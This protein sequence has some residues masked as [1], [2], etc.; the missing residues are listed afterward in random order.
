MPIPRL[1]SKKQLQLDRWFHDTKQDPLEAS[2]ATASQSSAANQSTQCGLTADEVEK[3]AARA[4]ARRNVL[5][6]MAKKSFSLAEAELQKV[7]RKFVWE[8]LGFVVPTRPGRLAHP[9]VPYAF[10]LTL[11]A[12]AVKPFAPPIL[13][14]KSFRDQVSGLC[15]QLRNT[16]KSDRM[17]RG[18]SQT[19]CA[20]TPGDG[21]ENSSDASKICGS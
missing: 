21:D 17:A 19:S 7:L 1:Q 8:A 15:S 3:R 12:E 18:G 2:A 4:F 5:Y 11:C 13:M 10:E 20:A 14:D 9:P 16:Q 6:A